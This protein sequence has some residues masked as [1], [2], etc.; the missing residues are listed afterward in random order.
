MQT[1]T[2][3]WVGGRLIWQPAHNIVFNSHGDEHIVV[4]ETWRQSRKTPIIQQNVALFVL[5][6]CILFSHTLVEAAH[7]VLSHQDIVVYSVPKNNNKKCKKIE[8][9]G[10]KIQMKPIFFLDQKNTY[11]HETKRSFIS[12]GDSRWWELGRSYE[13]FYFF[14]LAHFAFSTDPMTSLA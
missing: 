9:Q 6:F 2:Y 3:Q 5:S 10:K 11:V 4:W 7:V 14:H 8:Q 1:E 13:I 12:Q